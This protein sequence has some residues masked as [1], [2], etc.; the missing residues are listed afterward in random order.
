MQGLKEKDEVMA[1][2]QQLEE[3]SAHACSELPKLKI[4]TKVASA[5]KIQNLPAIVEE[6]KDEIGRIR[7]EQ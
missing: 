2:S 1:Q 3:A 5:K 4:P 6:S 7:F